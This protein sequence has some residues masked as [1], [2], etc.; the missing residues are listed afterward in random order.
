MQILGDIL[1]LLVAIVHSPLGPWVVFAFFA[2]LVSFGITAFY[3]SKVDKT[4]RVHSQSSSTLG[5][6]D[7]SH[8]NAAGNI[9]RK[10]AVAPERLWSYDEIYLDYFRTQAGSALDTYI[11]SVL[12]WD[13]LFAMSLG[14]FVVLFWWAVLMLGGWPLWFWRVAIFCECMGFLYG[15]AD[16]AE[17][18]KLRMIL[19]E[20]PETDPADAAAANLLTRIK[21]AAN[22]LSLAGVL[23]FGIASAVTWLIGGL[24]ADLVRLWAMVRNIRRSLRAEPAGGGLARLIRNMP[25]ARH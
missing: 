14:V 19:T 21:L 8:G 6:F 9:E 7:L 10:I 24:W 15:F 3:R 4:L 5:L 16:I 12:R 2:T 1:N 22:L 25:F 23:M 13:I 17:D 18:L 20:A 11:H